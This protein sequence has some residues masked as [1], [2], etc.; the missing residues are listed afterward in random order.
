M[1]IYLVTYRDFLL[2]MPNNIEPNTT[3]R[4]IF[5]FYSEIL[6]LNSEGDSVVSGDTLQSIGTATAFLLNAL[7]GSVTR[8]ALPYGQPPSSNQATQSTSETKSAS[9]TSHAPSTSS[10]DMEAAASHTVGNASGTLHEAAT[11]ALESATAA[12]SPTAAIDTDEHGT[13]TTAGCEKPKKSVLI[14]F[15]PDPGYF[16]AGAV[17]GGISRT[18]TAPLDRL[19]VYLLVNTKTDSAVSIHS[20]KS[21]RPLAVLKNAGRPLINAMADLYKSGGMRG[22]FAGE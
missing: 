18:A 13:G 3:L 9:S 7:F 14:R 15:L 2:F 11:A 6:T 1:L 20:I 22:F 17:A 4:A 8:I 21:G 19:K 5:S 10:A 16:V 12:T